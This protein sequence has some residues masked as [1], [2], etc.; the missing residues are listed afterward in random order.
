MRQVQRHTLRSTP[1]LP[2][3]SFN[4]ATS[5]VS[6]VDCVCAGCAAGRMTEAA[7]VWCVWGVWY[8]VWLWVAWEA[9]CWCACWAYCG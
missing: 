1:A 7:A 2:N 6:T 5:V 8:C 9:V 4:V 3:A